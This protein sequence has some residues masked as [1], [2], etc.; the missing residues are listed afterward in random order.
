MADYKER[1]FN[2][3]F[4]GLT[5]TVIIMAVVGACCLIGFESLRQLKRL[6]RRRFVEFWKEKK[7][8]GREGRGSIDDIGMS[9][10]RKNTQEDWEMGHLYHARTFHATTPS[11]ALA[12]WPLAW[13]WQALRLDDW[14]YATHC[15]MDNV[16]YVRFLR[17]C[18]WWLLLQT[19]TTAPILLTIHFKFSKGVPLTD[20]SRASLS[21]LVTI[22]KPGCTDTADTP[23]PR[24]PNE[25]G[26]KLLWIHL[27]LTWY[28]TATWFFALYWIGKGSL[29]VRRR[30]VEKI[31]TDRKTAHAELEEKRR[32]D[33]E[34]AAWKADRPDALM[35]KMQGLPA[36]EDNSEGWRQRTLLVT[37]LPA[38]MRDEASIRRYF[39]EFLR[40]DDA[41]SDGASDYNGHSRTG[42]IVEIPVSREETSSE[43]NEAAATKHAQQLMSVA[44]GP[45]PGPGP[46]L[47][48]NRHLGSP[49]QTVVLVR[50]MNELSAMLARRQEILQQLEAAHIKLAQNVMEKVKSKSDKQQDR[51]KGSPW[52]AFWRRTRQSQSGSSSPVHSGDVE[53]AADETAMRD[54]QK[55]RWNEVKR[56]LMPFASSE[57]QR[58]VADEK[59]HDALATVDA[60]G[61]NN[62]PSKEAFWEVL[63]DVPRDLLDPHQPVT[64]LSALFRGQKVPTIDYLLTK[65]NLLTALVAEMRARP[66]TDYEPT[67]TAFVTLRDP[68][69]ARMVWRELNSQIVVKVRMA[70]EVK[71]LDWD[72]LMRTSFTGA[73]V[74]GFGVNAFFWAFTVFWCIPL[75]LI[76]TALFS[77]QNLKHVVPGLGNLFESHQQLEAFISVTLPTVIVS[78]ISMAIPELVFQISKRAQGFVTW[79]A[80]YD[81]CLCRYWKFIVCNIVI[82]FCIGVT[83][84]ESILRQIGSPSS[85]SLILDNVAFSFPTA[86][87][88]FVSYFI[89]A[90]SLHS[91]FELLGFMIPILQHFLGANKATTPRAR[92]LKTLPRNFNRYYWLPFHILIMTI[93]F[94]FAILN[95]LII[96]FG[97]LYIFIAMIVF[98]KNFAFTYYR[99]FNEKEGVVYFIRLFRFTLDGLTTGQIVILIFFAVT[100]QQKAFIGLTALL[101][102][103]TVAF[104]ILGTK[105]WK[106]QVRA[107]EDDEAN[108]I[109][110]IATTTAS[111]FVGKRK[112]YGLEA[113]RDDLANTA[114]PA[115]ARASGRFPS[116]V[117]PPTTQSRLLRAWQR[118]HDSFHANG[119]D[120]PSYLAVRASRGHSIRHPVATTAGFVAKQPLNAVR[121]AGR[122]TRHLGHAAKVHLH[123]D[124]TAKAEAERDAKQA[125]EAARHDAVVGPRARLG[126]LE[127]RRSKSV[128][129]SQRRTTSRGGLARGLSTK[130]RASDETPFL[131]GFEAVA[132]HAPVASE[133]LTR[134]DLYDFEDPYADGEDS[135]LTLP[136][137]M[138]PRNMTPRSQRSKSMKMTHTARPH[139]KTRAISFSGGEAYRPAD[140]V[141]EEDGQTASRASAA[142]SD[143]DQ[144][145]LVG[146][147]PFSVSSSGDD[148]DDD[149]DEFDEY[150]EDEDSV[151]DGEE[152]PLVRPHAKIRWDDTPNNQ[153]RY[154]NPFYSCDL[155]PFLWLPRDP[156]APL[157]LCDTVEWHGPAFVSSDGGEGKVGEWEEDED[158]DDYDGDDADE[159]E[160]SEAGDH[161]TSVSRVRDIGGDEEIIIGTALAKRL[162]EE[163]DVEEVADPAAS[164]PKNVLDDYRKAIRRASASQQGS[165]FDPEGFAGGEQIQRYASNLSASS[166]RSPAPSV[167]LEAD[168]QFGRERPPLT[169]RS[170]SQGALAPPPPHHKTESGMPPSSSAESALSHQAATPAGVDSSIIAAGISS[171]DARKTHFAPEPERQRVRLHAAPAA[172]LGTSGSSGTIANLASAGGEQQSPTKLAS[173]YP[174]VHHRR[175]TNASVLSS[176][177]ASIHST[178]TQGPRTVTMRQALQAE[179]LEEERR[180]SIRD[181]LARTASR[182]TSTKKRSGG[183]KR[184]GS[185]KADEDAEGAEDADVAGDFGHLRRSST[186]MSRHERALSRRGRRNNASDHGGPSQNVPL[187]PTPSAMPPVRFGSLRQASSSA[188]QGIP[189]SDAPAPGQQS[190]LQAPTQPGPRR[191]PSFDR[192][193]RAIVAATGETMEMVE[194][195]SAA[196]AAA[197]AT[198]AAPA[199]SVSQQGV[200]TGMREPSASANTQSSAQLS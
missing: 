177:A 185:K 110:G 83:T 18:A 43:E 182:K 167:R 97:L 14:F 74:R 134:E 99:R 92:A 54:R 151:A 78:L 75:Q 124:K 176:G 59:E 154:N 61:S 58:E 87:P 73:L 101:L 197:T 84:V 68:R 184:P 49:V 103:I 7:G 85:K 187:S 98:K 150:G 186:I 19:L 13:T 108:A 181:R 123:L 135:F 141:L 82:F 155:D 81:Q 173:H 35:R 6:P 21:Y 170:E 29:S 50:K 55:A 95:P 22:S 5:T 44:P 126:A 129:R 128:H 195:G 91:G 96:P 38:T 65:L 34:A 132:N 1:N 166:I 80:L 16:V 90:I 115:D 160:L 69:Q 144:R 79:S 112:D 143:N 133:D 70:P 57:H 159:L 40:P 88:F 66:P 111:D 52:W 10:R 191:S 3:A 116:I 53:G 23:C 109:C 189:L 127:G 174:P 8:S 178:G 32:R 142:H 4:S 130:S 190:G 77:V 196:P 27:C 121:S 147:P 149:D 72:R 76:T 169:P 100:D 153:A 11:P 192:R 114:V 136:R 139:S 26:R 107:I 60:K 47:E 42:S 165:E 161:T 145:P 102:P 37:N 118:V 117:V 2:T 105:L 171:A 198:T 33:A 137:D 12:Q 24:Q 51:S 146:A 183:G 119:A 89:L 20:M 104:K 168:R 94:V 48:P 200:G 28:V 199:P 120:Q 93:V 9:T 71:D 164:L 15:G 63:A 125:E 179:V 39:E 36:N 140:A 162:E 163:Q 157:N 158:D 193:Q 152:G 86:A 46:D 31:K 172:P 156:M 30:L 131:S 194:L 113:G 67:S 64:S 138:Y 106:S 45:G 148:D 188:A 62:D 41:T 17:A 25:E 175:A 122:E 180:R 56:V